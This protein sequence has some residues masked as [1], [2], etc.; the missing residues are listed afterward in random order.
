[1]S[2]QRRPFSDLKNTQRI[3]MPSAAKLST[4]GGGGPV[5]GDVK[6]GSVDENASDRRFSY[7]P[8]EG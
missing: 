7:L 1:M 3:H 4:V 6:L 5:G 2:V 8:M